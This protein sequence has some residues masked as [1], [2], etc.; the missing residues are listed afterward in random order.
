MIC[1]T[2]RLVRLYSNISVTH[3]NSQRNDYEFFSSALYLQPFGSLKV[4]RRQ[5]KG[6]I[7]LLYIFYNFGYIDI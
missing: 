6:Y 4:K 1:S 7:S 5:R 2:F 3:E